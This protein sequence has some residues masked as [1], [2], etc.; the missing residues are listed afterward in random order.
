MKITELTN[1][2]FQLFI[3]TYPLSSIYQTVEY[4]LLMNTEG[5]DSI[6]LGLKEENKILAASVFLIEKGTKYKIA[7]APRGFL[8]DYTNESLLKTF[9]KLTKQYLDKRG[10]MSIRL[11]PLF[12]KNTYDMK[13]G[14]FFKNDTYDL[15]FKNL[16][17]LRY[18]HLGYNSY[19]EAMKPRFVAKINL[20]RPYYEIFQNIKKEYRTKIRSAAKRG[21]KIHV[22][23]EKELDY[24]YMHTQNKYPRDLAYF[25]NAY[26]YF[27]RKKKV[28]F[29]YAKLDTVSHLR[30]MQEEYQKANATYLTLLNK[31]NVDREHREKWIGEKIKQDKILEA[32]KHELIQA[33]ELLQNHPEGIITASILVVKER[34][35]VTVLMDGYNPKYKTFHA[36]HLLIW[37]LCEKYANEGYKTFNLGGIA[38]VTLKENK[39][40]GL[41]QF[42]LN[43]DAQ[44]IEYIGDLE[45]IVNHPL[46]LL[47]KTI[48]PI[49]DILKK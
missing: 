5:F 6:L 36:K 38:Q 19:F 42:K 22:G 4:A 49:P 28:E 26:K 11:S 21:I 1:D 48:P 20:D 44:A 7:Y 37:K 13:K 12:V 47:K 16:R 17:K 14:E 39:Y 18:K 41:N 33:S 43:F 8:L 2:E 34:T 24:L 35:E 15:V 29:F 27:S 46:Y 10:I 23:T 3:D 31:I 9:T 25:K 30:Y 32:K 40:A 45:L